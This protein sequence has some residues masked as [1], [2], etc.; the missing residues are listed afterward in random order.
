MAARITPGSERVSGNDS[1]T[2]IDPVR[3]AEIVPSL[4]SI[5]RAG[6]TI[7]GQEQGI[8]TGSRLKLRNRNDR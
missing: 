2:Q 6:Q 5:A 8:T 7:P 1:A 4:D 3:R